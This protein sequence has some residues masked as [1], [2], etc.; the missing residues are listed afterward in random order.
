MSVDE[1]FLFVRPPRPLWPFNGPGTAF[2]PPLAFASLA[3][4]LREK[5]RDLRVA[6]LDAP[7]LRMGWKSLTAEIQRLKPNYI[8]I[9]EEAVSCQ[10]GLRVA[11]LAKEAG[12]RVVAGG[13]FFGN[14]GPQ[15]VETGLID[16]VVQ[17]EG[18]ETIVD[19][20]PALRSSQAA[21]LRQVRG[22]YFLEDGEVVFTGHRPVIS[23]LDALPFP[24]YDLLPVE[25]YGQGSQNHAGLA[26]IESSRGCTAVCEFC[27]LWRQ[28][29]RFRQGRMGAAFRTKSPERLHEEIR[30]LFEKYGR[31]YLAW[32]DPC[33]NAHPEVPRR[34]AELLLRDN[35]KLGQSAWV[36]ADYLLRDQNSGALQACVKAGLNEV[37]LGIERAEKEGLQLFKKGYMNEEVAAALQILEDLYPSVFALGSFIYGLPTDTAHSV[38]RLARRAYRL[39]LDMTF[40]I[41]L[42]PLPGTPYW[43]PELWDPTG[44]RFREFDFLPHVD[45]DAHKTRL[46]MTLLWASVFLWPRARVRHTFGNLVCRQARRRSITRRHLSRTIPFVA[47]GIVRGL[48]NR[49]GS[50]GMR[51]PEWYDG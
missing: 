7:A 45:G 36:R 31:R 10:E 23:D 8:G 32:V 34:L 27:V 19:L 29:G 6:I 38:W 18:E 51:L 44:Q 21:D 14:V 40:F 24:A 15:A 49:G 4:A 17:G 26:A 5:V 20:L 47:S 46:T 33:F 37:Y 39:P 11:V 35:F 9:G 13:C 41:P 25:R 48:L 12:A 50:Y 3:A 30:I 2:W 43:K 22:I 42:T 28:M 16:I 1:L